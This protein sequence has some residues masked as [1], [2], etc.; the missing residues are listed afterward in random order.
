MAVATVSLMFGF[1][2]C[3]HHET[4]LIEPEKF[5]NLPDS[6]KI[7]LLGEI[8]TPNSL[9][10]WICDNV[11]NDS[12]EYRLDFNEGI[13]YAYNYYNGEDRKNFAKSLDT[14]PS[15]LTAEQ[16]LKIYFKAGKETPY[17]LG[18]LIAEDIVSDGVDIM[19]YR[20]GYSEKN[21]LETIRNLC[22]T[23]TTLFLK[24]KKGIE[25]RKSYVTEK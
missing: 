4:G 10:K 8:M 20:G 24:I 11:A 19:P 1:T 5:N 18:F 13:R 22:G 17:K 12:T 21:I 14:Y 7:I 25:T 6:S 15:T 16:C 9:A 3:M 2:F 23:D